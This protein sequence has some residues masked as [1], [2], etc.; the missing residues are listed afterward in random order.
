MSWLSRHKRQQLKVPTSVKRVCA[1]WDKSGPLGRFPKC[2][3]LV[4]NIKGEKGSAM[5][6]TWQAARD[7]TNFGQ[8]RKKVNSLL[9]ATSLLVITSSALAVTTLSDS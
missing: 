5:S 1:R 6:A 8:N 9:L 4:Y 3:I 7:A 2:Y